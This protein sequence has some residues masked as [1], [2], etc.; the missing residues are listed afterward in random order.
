MRVKF[1]SGHLKHLRHTAALA[2]RID[3]LQIVRIL[4][5]SIAAINENVEFLWCHLLRAAMSLTTP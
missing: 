4:P 5:R 3:L 1:S 2:E